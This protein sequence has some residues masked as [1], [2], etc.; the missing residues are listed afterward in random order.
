MW[1]GHF[2]EAVESAGAVIAGLTEADLKGYRA[3]WSY[4]AGSAAWCGNQ[5]SGAPGL[6][7]RA[8]T[9]FAQAREASSGIK[10]LA[11]LA[12]YQPESAAEKSDKQALESQV[13]RLEALLL[14][15]GTL[16]EAKYSKHEKMILD[17]IAGNDPKVFEAAHRDLG[18]NARFSSRE[19]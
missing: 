1:Q 4:L 9:Y 11:S 3:L 16:H 12:R 14:K 18:E 10:W 8:R 17:G 6:A 13:E 2:G 19:T 15:L 5:Q 7:A